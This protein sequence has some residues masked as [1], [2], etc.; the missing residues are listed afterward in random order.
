MGIQEDIKELKDLM[1]RMQEEKNEKGFRLPFGKKVGNRQRRKNYVTVQILH[2][3]GTIDYKKLPIE[4]QTITHDLIPRL[5]TAGYVM[6]WKKNPTI[7]L[8]NWSVEP[9]SPLEHYQK[10]LLNGSNV[11]GYKILMAKMH[12]EQVTDKPKMGNAIKWIIGLGLAGIIIYAILT[13]GGG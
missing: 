1:V 11:K 10:S 3:N 8:P 7:I 13:S 9:F 12:K 2:E 5:A 4:D 6:Y